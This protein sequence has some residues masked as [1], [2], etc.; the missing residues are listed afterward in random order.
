MGD[1]NKGEE[2]KA[3]HAPPSNNDNSNHENTNNDVQLEIRLND[4]PV[5]EED[6]NNTTPSTLLPASAPVTP[7]LSQKHPR[8]SQ[9]TPLSKSNR[10]SIIETPRTPQ[11]TN[12]RY[13]RPEGGQTWGI[14]LANNPVFLW[15]LCCL[16]P[17]AYLCIMFGAIPIGERED[18][19]DDDDDDGP[20]PTR[21][22]GGI[23][24]I[25]DTNERFYH[26]WVFTCVVNPINMTV[27]SFLLSG[28]FLSCMGV[29]RPFRVHWSILGSCFALQLLIFNL[30][31]PFEGTFNFFGVVSLL[32]AY[33]STFAG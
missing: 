22:P 26:Y 18:D 31:V 10:S 16:V 7:N 5:K 11:I 15:L 30:I 20:A 33:I 23:P 17:L 19:D 28:I 32:V 12:P 1:D 9:L 6:L 3:S 25:H 13:T 27:I 29:M 21:P 4:V 2:E 24:S 14:A 8:D